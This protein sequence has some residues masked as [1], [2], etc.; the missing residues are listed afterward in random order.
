MDR[1]VGGSMVDN[2]DPVAILQNRILKKE[3][4]GRASSAKP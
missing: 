4:I 3:S 1:K 2:R